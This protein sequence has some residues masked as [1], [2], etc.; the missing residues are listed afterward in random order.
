MEKKTKGYLST[1]NL[2]KWKSKMNVSVVVGSVMMSAILVGSTLAFVPGIANAQVNGVEFAPVQKYSVTTKLAT[3]P[4]NNQQSGTVSIEID[5]EKKSFSGFVQN[6]VVFVP[7]QDVFG[8]L[9][10]K[11][12]YDNET[13]KYHTYKWYSNG[14][15]MAEFKNGSDVA[16]IN[17]VDVKLQAKATSKNGALMIPASALNKALGV[18]VSVSGNVVKIKTASTLSGVSK[19]KVK[20]MQ[21]MFGRHAYGS[22]NQNEYDE[23]MK[24]VKK[25]LD[26]VF[27]PN[28]DGLLYGIN[29]LEEQYFL[30][31][32][33]GKRWDGNRSNDSPENVALYA[34]EEYLGDLVRAGVKKEVIIEIMK[35]EKAARK[36]L[37]EA[38]PVDVTPRS[39]Y[40]ALVKRIDDC[41]STANTLSAFYDAMG[42]N[43]MIVGMPNHALVLVEV[44]GYWFEPAGGTYNVWGKTSDVIK[45][46]K[47][48]PA[49]YVYEQPT[50]GPYWKN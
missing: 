36:K 3:S 9:G 11:V 28:W 48:D 26:R 7:L 17:G 20:G 44:N 43:T 14:S 38:N 27:D 29:K 24:I 13:Y 4:S 31:Y 21:V 45:M 15:V 10:A 25:E 35:I 22:L 47:D 46:I 33:D 41:D 16:V 5:E 39:A 1:E 40:D 23:V 19:T 18:S 30:S 50:F 6:G 49:L 42:Y 37:R 34:A 32:L 8:A 2:P 12:L